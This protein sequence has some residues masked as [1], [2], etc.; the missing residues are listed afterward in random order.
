MDSVI[1][2]MI[3]FSVLA[4]TAIS[5]VL[6]T[7]RAKKNRK[8]KRVL[9]RLEIEKNVIDSTPIS[10]EL[11]KIEAY[12]KNEKLNALYNDW[13]ERLDVIKQNQI[14]KLT[15]MI[16]EADYSLSQNDYKSTLCKIAR[17]EMETYKVRTNSE[18]LLNEIKEITTSEERN[19]AIITKMKSDFREVYQK[20]A[21]SKASF[22]EM[23]GPV[24]LQFEN[25]S[26]R[27][28]DFETAMDNND[29]TELNP[30]LKAIDEMLHH[31]N[32]VV[33]EVPGIVLLANNMLPKKISELTKMYEWM[34]RAGFPLDY[35]NVEYN[36]EEA[37]K[38]I[39][40]VL[41]RTKV[42]NLEDCLFELKV[43]SEYFDTLFADL[44][45]EKLNRSVYEETEK[46]FK[47]KLG[48]LNTLIDDIFSQINEIKNIY[49]LSKDDINLLNEI[50]TEIKRLNDDYKVL[51]DHTG[52]NTFAYS[53][54]IKEMEALSM[55]LAHLEEQLDSSLDTI[56]SMR[57]DEVRARQQLEEIKVI[58]K[59]AKNKMRDFNLPYIPK[60]YFT[61]LGEAQD[62]IKEIVKELEKKPITI[63]TLNT[64]VD[65]ARDLAFK[66][67]GKTKEMIKTAM[68]AEM[69]IVYGNRYRTE[70]EEINKNLTYSEVLFYKGEYQ[71]SLEL[72]IN[73]LNRIEPGIY[74]KLLNFYGK[75]Q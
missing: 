26:H 45:K 46:N 29:Y 7:M 40:D 25:I 22:G 13:K 11:S 51:N 70:D 57:E 41:S 55:R 36:I 16:I 8:Y 12:L 35:L 66:L 5:I 43:L 59:D 73:S 47:K 39:E 6:F 14:P 23:E 74:D 31:M 20:F 75:E 38:K 71:K 1:L 4:M 3:T 58:L 30:I 49:N 33:E 52:N 24:Q 15:D 2:I 44:E 54:L 61:E 28:E 60:S 72:T 65:T 63:Q 18:F 21:A 32:V 50:Y 48:N 37:K 64:R 34:V 68:F 53:Q 42:L 56:G 62:A 27:F 17:L 19:R 67:F 9:D 10:P 69:A